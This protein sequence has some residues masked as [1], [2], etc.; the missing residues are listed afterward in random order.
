MTACCDMLVVTCHTWPKIESWSW[1]E[2][3]HSTHV[4]NT[5]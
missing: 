3:C 4:N 2:G 1:E 5:K